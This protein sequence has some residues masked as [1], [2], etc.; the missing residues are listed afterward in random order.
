MRNRIWLIS[1]LNPSDLPLEQFLSTPSTDSSIT[2]YSFSSE[3]F[4]RFPLI[5]PYT[6]ATLPHLYF[7]WSAYML[8]S[9][10]PLFASLCK[11]LF[12]VSAPWK[13]HETWKIHEIHPNLSVNGDQW[14]PWL[15]WIRFL[16]PF[17][18]FLET[19]N[20]AW[21]GSLIELMLLMIDEHLNGYDTDYLKWWFPFLEFPCSPITLN[22]CYSNW[23]IHLL[24]SCCTIPRESRK[25]NHVKKQVNTDNL[26]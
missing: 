6:A 26:K 24:K 14:N 10:L 11:L 9:R 7:C 2:P 20:T 4:W 8:L 17:N 3:N 25:W 18:F 22:T 13:P 16:S 12:T 5:T 19:R 1:Y 21:R 15:N 23:G